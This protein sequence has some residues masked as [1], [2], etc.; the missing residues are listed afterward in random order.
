MAGSFAGPLS[1]V[2]ALTACR[3]ASVEP[4][5]A[6]PSPQATAEPAP[7]A[8]P[9]VAPTAAAADV[10]AGPA[11]EPLRSDRGLLP[12][13]PRE[14][15]A[16][17]GGTKEGV[18]DPRGP[19]GYT[20]QVILRT[21]EGPPAPKAPEVNVAVIEGAR[22]RTEAKLAI[23]ISPGR[24]RFTVT[25]S[26]F[27]LP[28][29]TELRSRSDRYGH[30]LL[31]PGEN[32]YRVAEPGSLRAL[33]GERRLDVAPISPADLGGGGEG[34]RRLNLSTRRI[35]VSTRAAKAT[36][37]VT[38]L[39]DAGDG[40][41]LVYRF[42]LDLMNAPPSTPACT[43]D[44]VPLHA[45]LHWTT[46]GSLAF[47]VTSITRTN[48]LAVQD[49]AAPPPSLIFSGAPPPTS[50]AELLVQ[51]GDLGSFRTGPIDVPLAATRD[52]T[53][54]P[55]EAGLLLLNST[56]EL[57]LAWIDGVPAAWVGPGAR[58]LLP[59]LARGRYALQWR[60]ALGDA[61]EPAVTAFAPGVSEVGG[62]RS[63][64]Q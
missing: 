35:D 63:A 45:E 11:P 28:Q 43:T 46:Q 48:D 51:R 39:R 30:L 10:E 52:A 60:T 27:V 8:N 4:P 37:E 6:A 13:T 59:W 7:F 9:P 24:A 38:T 54:P 25:G 50:P 31:W 15:S 42:L 58:L 21:G 22:R 1:V 44:D 18:R 41:C 2:I 19:N 29:G 17:D 40:G 57:R 47:D 14:A 20:L 32:S 12:D 55:P 34:G 62:T 53:R 3:G 33:L 61:W 36:F 5:D 49:M 23:A 64:T 56:D 26:G 16:R